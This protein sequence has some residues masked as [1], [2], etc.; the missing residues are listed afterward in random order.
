M[1]WNEMRCLSRG[2]L[3]TAAGDC[4]CGPACL[5]QKRHDPCSIPAPDSADPVPAPAPCP[6]PAGSAPGAAE[7]VAAAVA[8]SMEWSLRRP[9]PGFLQWQSVFCKVIH[10]GVNRS[11]IGQKEVL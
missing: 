2:W 9:G 6:Y 8:A 7:V 4:D 3:L 10:F 1:E 5:R 11:R